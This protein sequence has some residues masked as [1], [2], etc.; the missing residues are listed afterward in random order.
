MDINIDNGLITKIW[1]PHLWKSLHFITFGYPINPTEEQKIEYRKFFESLAFVL[2]CKYCRESYHYFINNE[3]TK[4]NNDI[5][6]NRDSI[7]KWLYLLH[8]RVNQKLGVDY[9]VTY[10]EVV[11]KYESFRA[12]CSPDLQGCIMP[13]NMKAHSY[14]ND[15]LKDY[16]IICLQIANA[17]K[18]YATKRGIEFNKLD[19]YND[20]KNNKENVEWKKRNLQCQKIIRNMRNDGIPSIENDGLYKGLPTI[21]ELQLI[22]LLC[23]NMTKTELLIIAK[24]LNNPIHI[25]YKLIKANN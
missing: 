12:K 23:S 1:G 13:A 19:Y 16:P 4:I 11:K 7:T 24:K 9:N 20:L 17:L 3:P 6:N 21:N 14:Q 5:F 10:D 18:D 22:S 25:K 15:L 2:P 8:D